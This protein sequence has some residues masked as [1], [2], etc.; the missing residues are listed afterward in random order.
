MTAEKLAALAVTAEKIAALAI[1]AEKIAALAVSTDKLAA[2]AV[3]AEKIAALAITTDKIAANAIVAAK[4]AAGAI[5]ADAVGANLIITN[6]ANIADAI[7][8]S[9]KIASLAADKITAGIINVLVRLNAAV[10]VG[11]KV[12]SSSVVF[13]ASDPDYEDSEFPAETVLEARQATDA[14]STNGVCPIIVYGWKTGTGFALD[15]FGKSNPVFRLSFNGVVDH[16]VTIWWRS[17][18]SDGSFG[19]W[20]CLDDSEAI[21][22]LAGYGQVSTSA[23]F[24][25]TGEGG[26]NSFQFA[27]FGTD[28][29]GNFFDNAK[30][31][32]RGK[33]TVTVSNL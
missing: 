31:L 21:E 10:L 8:T 20:V 33:L 7:I 4:I 12:A 17:R 3:T 16:Y 5:T 14:D 24:T 28:K 11:A 2:N 26:F 23:I 27:V 13:N 32:V 18:F 29:F 25:P 1:T 30:K 15:R 9:A 22:P 6:T 19:S